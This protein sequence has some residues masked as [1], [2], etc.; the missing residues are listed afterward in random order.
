MKIARNYAYLQIEILNFTFVWQAVI[1]YFYFVPTSKISLCRM[2]NINLQ[3]DYF[4]ANNFG[5]YINSQ[6]KNQ[7]GR[8]YALKFYCY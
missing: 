1:V 6:Q 7:H 4:F 8:L 3:A 2:P 5:L